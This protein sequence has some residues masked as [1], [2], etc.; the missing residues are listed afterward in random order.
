M[1]LICD[2][3]WSWTFVYWKFIFLFGSVLGD[4]AF[5]RICPF[6]PGCLFYRHMVA[7]RRIAGTAEPSGLTSMGSHRVGH[8]WSNLAAAAGILYI[9]WICDF[10]SYMYCIYLLPICDLTFQ[11]PTWIYFWKEALN[12]NVVQIITLHLLC[13]SAF[14]CCFY[15]ICF[16]LKIL[17]QHHKDILTY[18]ILKCYFPFHI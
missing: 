8:D 5:L 6:L 9:F 10:Y 2:A 13:N 18:Y 1:E 12:F 16:V 11:A 3:I 7:C 17:Y 4:C 15:F 14:L